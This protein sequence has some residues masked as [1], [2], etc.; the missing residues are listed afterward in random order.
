[1]TEWSTS[2][3]NSPIISQMD[4]PAFDRRVRQERATVVLPIG[5]LEQH[6]PHSPIGSDE[7]LTKIIAEEVARRTNALAAPSVN[8]GVR[9]QPRTGGGDHFPGTISLRG[10][11]LVRLVRDILSSFVRKGAR[12]ILILDTHYENEFF[13]IEGIEEAIRELRADGIEDFK[14]VKIRYFELLDDAVLRIVFPDGFLGWALEH[15]AVM[16]TSLHLHLTPELVDMSKAPT[17]GP[18]DFPPYDVFPQDPRRSTQTGCLSSPAPATAEKGRL[19][20]ETVVKGL[21]EVIEHEFRSD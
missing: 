1:M 17:H 18:T 2:M 15:A 9:S 8:Y 10:D 16:T 19:I 11:T 7:M 4:W 12:S 14:I 3:P 21:V 5:S 13:V 6:G 20:Y